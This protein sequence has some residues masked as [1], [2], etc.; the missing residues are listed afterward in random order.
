LGWENAKMS[1]TQVLDLQELLIYEEE[2]MNACFISEW[3]TIIRQKMQKLCNIQSVIML[4]ISVCYMRKD[5][6]KY[7]YHYTTKHSKLIPLSAPG[8]IDCIEEPH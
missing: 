6:S 4:I 3:K 2:E 1:K 5:L 7:K 8:N